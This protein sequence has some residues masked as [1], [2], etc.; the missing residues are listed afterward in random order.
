MRIGSRWH[1]K[2]RAYLNSFGIKFQPFLLVDKEF[3]DV[4]T[5]VALKLNNLAHFSI[6][7]DGA[8]ACWCFNDPVWATNTPAQMY[9]EANWLTE[10]LLYDFEYFLLIKFLRKPLNSSQ[11][12]TAISLCS[13]LKWKLLWDFLVEEKFIK[14][15]E[16]TLDPN[17]NVVLWLLCLPGLLVGFGERVYRPDVS[18]RPLPNQCTFEGGQLF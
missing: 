2:T 11:G 5:L 3:L 15:R 13:T 10:L 8:I 1:A 12:L 6:V 4:F 9:N 16:R 14:R 18:K 17:V 7:H